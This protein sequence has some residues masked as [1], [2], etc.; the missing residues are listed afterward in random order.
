M[1]YPYKVTSPGYPARIRVAPCNSKVHQSIP[2]ILRFRHTVQDALAF[3]VETSG[4]GCVSELTN[5]YTVIGLSKDFNLRVC[6]FHS[7][8]N[9]VVINL[10]AFNET[11]V[12]N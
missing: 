3:R 8:L 5:F 10:G 11:V 12:A 1:D 6:K 9:R 4:S 7:Q 2:R